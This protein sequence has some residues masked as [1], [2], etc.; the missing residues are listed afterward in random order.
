MAAVTDGLG[1]HSLSGAAY[2]LGGCKKRIFFD[3]GGMGMDSFKV[4]VA[5]ALFLASYILSPHAYKSGTAKR[6]DTA[7][8]LIK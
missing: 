5:E 6:T 4:T 3:H 2:S 8:G 7:A 1:A